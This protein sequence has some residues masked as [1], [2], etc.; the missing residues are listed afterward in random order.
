MV[1]DDGR[2]HFEGSA[3]ELLAS[4]DGYLQ[5]FLSMTLPPW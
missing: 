2:I 1:L 3:A 5:E 4:R